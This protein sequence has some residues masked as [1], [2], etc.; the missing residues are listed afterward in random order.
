M[1][2]TPETSVNVPA[3]AKFRE[4]GKRVLRLVLSDFCLFVVNR[5]LH[6]RRGNIHLCDFHRLHAAVARYVVAD[7]IKS[8]FPSAPISSEM[9]VA[10]W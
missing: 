2:Y 8:L 1:I 5:R 6:C 7:D 4:A 9:G 10:D 3:C